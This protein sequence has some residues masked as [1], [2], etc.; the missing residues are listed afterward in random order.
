MDDEVAVLVENL[1]TAQ[2]EAIPEDQLVR[3]VIASVPRLTPAE[4]KG[5]VRALLAV[6]T[7]RT[8]HGDSLAGFAN[9]IATSVSLDL[10]PETAAALATRLERLAETPTIALTAKAM[11]IA[12][13]HDRVFHTARVVTDIRPVYG[14]DATEPPFGAVITHVLRIDAFRNGRLEDYYVAL[15]NSNLV[16]LRHAVDRAL[17]KND[18]LGALLD[19]L[20]FTQFQLSEE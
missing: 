11:D 8:V 3:R 14:D 10:Q 17:E 16:H 19:N 15:D 13:E 2:P 4:A 6:Q 7:M 9:D 1:A 18:S 12:Q 5:I 20:G